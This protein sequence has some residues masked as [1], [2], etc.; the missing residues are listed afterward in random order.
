MVAAYGFDYRTEAEATV[1]AAHTTMLGIA[2]GTVVV[3][4]L[5]AAAFAYSLCRPIFAAMHV[6]ERVAAGNFADHIKVRRS[7]ELGRLLKS[8][9]VMQDSLKSRADD[10][11]A[12]SSA[13]DQTHAE[14]VSRRQRIEAEIEGFRSTFVTVLANTDRMTGE[15]TDTAQSLS[16]IAQRGRP[17]VDRGGIDRR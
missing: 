4:L 12:L 10:D 16:S 6:A 11:L 7:D 3:G 17:A 5:I 8:L 15:L 13:K 1:A 9:A 14:Q 2:I